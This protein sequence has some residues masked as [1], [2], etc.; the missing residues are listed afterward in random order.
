MRSELNSFH[1]V[2]KSISEEIQVALK[3]NKRQYKS[4]LIKEY[5]SLS[6]NEGVISFI[7]KPSA[8]ETWAT[9]GMILFC[10]P[11]SS[12]NLE[13]IASSDIR[14]FDPDTGMIY[15][16]APKLNLEGI[17]ELKL[18][19]KPFDFADAVQNAYNRLSNYPAILADVLKKTCGSIEPSCLH[20]L[21]LDDT[22]GKGQGSKKRISEIWQLPWSVLWGPPGTGKTQSIADTA[23]AFAGQVE[24]EKILILT[25][26][27][28]A[29]DEVAYRICDTLSKINNLN[30]PTG[31]LVYRG[32]RGAGNRLSKTFPE[33]LRDEVYARLFDEI[34]RKIEVLT[35]M[36]AEALS[37]K[38]YHLAIQYNKEIQKLKASLPD[39]TIFAV[40]KGNAKVIVL[41][42]YGALK[43][44]GLGEDARLVEKVIVDE[45][46]M[47]S[48]M[49]TA[50]VTSLGRSVLLAGDPKQIGPIFTPQ[51]GTSM[52]IKKWL[53]SSGLSHLESVKESLKLPYVCFLSQQHRMHPEISRAVSNFTYDGILSDSEKARAMKMEKPFSPKYPPSRATCILLDLVCFNPEDVCPEKAA[54]GVGKQRNFSAQIAMSLAVEAGIK[55]ADVL[56]LTPYRAQV[57]LLR[58]KLP[59]HKKELLKRINVG[60]IHRQQ[61]A[62]RDVVILDTVNG[63]GAWP[64]HEIDM[65]LNV[66]ISRAKKHFILVASQAELFSP[67][68]ARLAVLLATSGLNVPV[69][70]EKGQQMLL[71]E[72]PPV[73]HNQNLG[74]AF[75]ASRLPT[76]LGE[77]IDAAVKTVIVS[78]DQKKIIERNIGDGHY[79]V[80]GVAGS[81]K[82]IILAHWVI[83]TLIKHNKAR[84]LITYF[85]KGIKNLLEHMLEEAC[86]MNLLN[87]IK[88]KTQ[89]SV[90]HIDGV[91]ER[92][93]PFDSVFVDE[94]QDFSPVQ[95][96]KAFSL[97]KQVDRE[98]KKQRNFIL[99]YDDS[100]NIY[101]RTTIEEFKTELEKTSETGN[102]E[103]AEKLSFAGRSFVLRETYRSTQAILEF[104]INM[105]LDPKSIYSKSDLGL[106]KFM[107]VPEL[108][109]EDL[110]KSPEKTEN[111]QYSI[112]YAERIGTAPIII[113]CPKEDMLKRLVKEISML[114]ESERVSPGSIMVVCSKKPALIAKELTSAGIM[115]KGYGGKDGVNPI[116]L[117]AVKPDHVRC[118]TLHSCKGHEAPIVMFFG[119]NE[120]EDIEWMDSTPK[121][122][123][124]KS[125]RCLLY[126]G[127]T[128]A[129]V[130]IYVFGNT[131]ALMSAAKEYAGLDSSVKVIA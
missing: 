26:T 81:G 130:R 53:M 114:Q 119:I 31:C 80:R 34:Q 66:A 98:G 9:G 1:S 8:D 87:I 126:V 61:G 79:M 108:I 10:A 85:N 83:R 48:R 104:A 128:R 5:S 86:R 2:Q 75:S 52:A 103:L 18:L 120:L 28:N 15:A 30:A 4:V 131:S 118:V 25:P 121:N 105:A 11:D 112:L 3:H 38:N 115:A 59:F 19:Y 77:E 95:M 97:C 63:A 127:I 58:K 122:M 37:I 84:I 73:P 93:D 65:M 36:R 92:N 7:P 60:T 109:K 29:A 106:L 111:G 33:C 101:G 76:T 62:E 82:S 110:I 69:Y 49:T 107:R 72:N 13:F 124:E 44:V 21:I 89:V 12:D 57:S 94:A 47:V 41:T 56:I 125:M 74:L 51:P 42:T 70:N 64:S 23:A 88:V 40:T 91:S 39:E 96:V 67:S 117:P 24:N 113:E 102:L 45:A 129:M 71:P 55:G 16:D 32:G 123:I 20:P 100:Q 46:G 50:A 78:R 22:D 116:E 17:Q 27:N 99:F 35:E 6:F 43:L 54:R 90:I 68:L 14:E